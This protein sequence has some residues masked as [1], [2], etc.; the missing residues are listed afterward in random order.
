MSPYTLRLLLCLSQLSLS[1]CGLILRWP[2]CNFL[3]SLSSAVLYSAGR[4][5]SR[6]QPLLRAIYLTRINYSCQNF[7]ER[8]SRALISSVQYRRRS[9]AQ[10]LSLLFI[11][12]IMWM[13]RCLAALKPPERKLGLSIRPSRCV[14]L[15]ITASQCGLILS[16]R[17]KLSEQNMVDK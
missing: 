4:F 6:K 16:K 10:S 12:K 1:L 7:E 17:M 3:L 14:S 8:E 2:P 11:L 13:N 5:S 15:D 9:R